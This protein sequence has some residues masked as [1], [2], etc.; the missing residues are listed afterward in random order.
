ML[1]K[2]LKISISLATLIAGAGL[3]YHFA[4]YIPR[5][6][7][8]RALALKSEQ[9]RV[10]VQY[11]QCVDTAEFEH[12]YRFDNACA[13]SDV[14]RTSLYVQCYRANLGK[15]CDQ[16]LDKSICYIDPEIKAELEVK[17]EKEKQLCLTK[18]RNKL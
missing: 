6:D 5:Q 8:V 18:V 15:Y 17:L 11:Q 13:N 9:E 10:R 12:Q 1:D 14:Y 2:L 7:E 4:I 16:V 3:F